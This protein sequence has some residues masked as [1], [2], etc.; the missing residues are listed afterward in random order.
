MPS[1]LRLDQWKGQ[2]GTRVPYLTFNNQNKESST[3]DIVGDNWIIL[4]AD[5][6]W[7]DI[8][9]E[10]VGQFEATI[11]IFQVTNK[12]VG[13]QTFCDAFG[14]S[15]EGAVVVRPDGVIAWRSENRPEDTRGI[16]KSALDKLLFKDK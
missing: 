13:K 4:T 5:K 9:Q 1:A 11:D 8:A 2:P 7:K 14:I 12:N 3:L 10:I 16:L 6:V 15:E